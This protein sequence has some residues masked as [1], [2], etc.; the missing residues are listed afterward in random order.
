MDWPCQASEEAGAGGRG[1]WDRG[2]EE[3]V[4]KGA[5][6]WVSQFP[7]SPLR[8]SGAKSGPSLQHEPLGAVSC[9]GFSVEVS[10]LIP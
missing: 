3:G 5:G 9:L 4:G 10:V 1:G 7:S 6:V 2:E 8:L